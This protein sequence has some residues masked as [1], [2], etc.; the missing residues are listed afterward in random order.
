M[1]IIL[2]MTDYR[3]EADNIHYAARQRSDLSEVSVEKILEYEDYVVLR[4][5]DIDEDF[6][7]VSLQITT[8]EE[9]ILENDFETNAEVNEETN[10][11]VD[12]EV[13]EESNHLTTLY[14]DHREIENGKIMVDDNE[15]DVEY[16]TSLLVERSEEDIEKM[17]EDIAKI[18]EAKKKLKEKWKS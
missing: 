14:I 13:D 9:D 2:D 6:L 7:Q 5:S 1:E 3:H 15:E 17:K 11:E 4:I 8:E 10:E 12:E 18:E 16:I